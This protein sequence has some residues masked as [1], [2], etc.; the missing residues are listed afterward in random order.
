MLLVL[1]Y[2]RIK[3]ADVFRSFARYISQNHPV[4]I[5]GDALPPGKLSICHTFDD[6]Y[7]DFYHFVYN[8]PQKLDSGI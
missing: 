3:N 5:P 7:Y 1:M 6:A 8:T 2:H 4:V